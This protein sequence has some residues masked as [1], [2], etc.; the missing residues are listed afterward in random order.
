M[1]GKEKMIVSRARAFNVGSVSH[2]GR[3]EQSK[4]NHLMFSVLTVCGCDEEGS[5]CSSHLMQA[6]R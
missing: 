1:E 6:K 5:A 4:K 3:R 2:S